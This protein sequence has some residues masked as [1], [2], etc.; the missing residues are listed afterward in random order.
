MARRG[1]VFSMKELPS[2]SV[3]VVFNHTF[4][5]RNFL[6]AAMP[7]QFQK[8]CLNAHNNYRAQHG[9]PPLKWSS[10]LASDAEKWA[11]ELV[12][13][14]RLQHHTGDDG[15]N[16][17]FASGSFLKLKSSNNFTIN[18]T[19]ALRCDIDASLPPTC[20]NEHN[21]IFTRPNQPVKSPFASFYFISINVK[22]P[23]GVGR[24]H[25]RA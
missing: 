12:K 2:S 14:N 23:P 4:L 25:L 24:N 19:H 15:E 20:E 13:L 21:I 7:N 16:L 17:A 11:K 1:H 10:K 22:E 8:D 18:L 9:A 6:V 3:I 5:L